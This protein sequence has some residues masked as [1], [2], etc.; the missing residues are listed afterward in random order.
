MFVGVGAA[1]VRDLF[2][3]AKAQAPAIVFIDELDAVGRKRGAGGMGGGNDERDQTLNQL[4]SELDGFDS[5]KGLV[6]IAATN[7]PDV[8]DTALIRPGRFD[9]KVVVPAPDAAGRLEI[10]KVH[11][12]KKPVADDVDLHEIANDARGFT[13]AALANLVN[14]AALAAARDVAPRIDMEHLRQALEAELMGKVIGARLWDPAEA[15]WRDLLAS[16][17]L[18]A[19]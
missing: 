9:R 1:R 19:A 8:L 16:L 17:P 14:Q 2:E 18:S 13:G 6:V 3:Q 7:R 15:P 4:L 5:A 12:R 10:L 11:L